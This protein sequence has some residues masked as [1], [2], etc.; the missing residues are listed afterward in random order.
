MS[1]R[2]KRKRPR[3]SRIWKGVKAASLADPMKRMMRDHEDV[4]QNI[5]ATLVS[6]HRKEPGIDD[7]AIAD[8]LRA[9]LAGTA[10]TEERR[11]RLVGALGAVRKI[12]TDIPDSIWQDGL[13]VVLASVRRHSTLRPGATGYLDFVSPFIV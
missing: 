9:A 11:R 7:C 10:P 13:R 8:A 4:L 3:V 2:S 6:I 1:K 5:E 12:R